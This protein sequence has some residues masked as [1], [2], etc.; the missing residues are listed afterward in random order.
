MG[1]NLTKRLTALITNIENGC[2]DVKFQGMWR[3]LGG[4]R[5]PFQHHDHGCKFPGSPCHTQTM[6]NGNALCSLMSFI[7]Q[8]ITLTRSY[9]VMYLQYEQYN[10]VIICT[11]MIRNPHYEQYGFLREH[12]QRHIMKN[13]CSSK[14]EFNASTVLLPFPVFFHHW[15]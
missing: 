8:H 2:L 11:K 6:T 4:S 15:R 9:M 10:G 12:L 1:T 5:V 13:K 3:Y 14:P 7:F